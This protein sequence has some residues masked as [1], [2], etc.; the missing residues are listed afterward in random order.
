MLQTTNPFG[1]PVVGPEK[2]TTCWR[3]I[4]GCVSLL[5]HVRGC[6]TTPARGNHSGRASN[7]RANDALWQLAVETGKV[8]RLTD[9]S[10]LDDESE[11]VVGP[12]KS[13]ERVAMRSCDESWT[14]FAC[15]LT[16]WSD[17]LRNFV[18]NGQ[19][20]MVAETTM[21]IGMVVASGGVWSRSFLSRT[22]VSIIQVLHMRVFSD[23]FEDAM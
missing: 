11:R 15:G 1:A 3:E 7:V 14:T 2:E 17:G 19:R 13:R 6:G 8:V 5:V 9:I 20:V 18:P 21:R 4:V 12:R 23:P 16:S 22:G 10:K